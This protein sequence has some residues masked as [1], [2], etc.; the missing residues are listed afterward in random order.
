M[1]CLKALSAAGFGMP[2][3]AQIASGQ[4]TK[5]HNRYTNECER[6]PRFDLTIAG[7]INL[8]LI[9]YGVP[10]ELPRERE[11][12]ADRMMLTLGGSSAIMAH[13]LASLGSRV[14]FQSR[15]GDDHLGE[16]ALQPLQQSGVDV[17]QVRR[18]HGEI[19]TGITVILQRQR[20]RNMVTYAGT[21]AELTWDDLDFDYLTDSRHFHVSSFYLQRGLR[22]RIPELFR[23]MKDSGLTV[24]L[25]TNDDPDD[26]WEGGLDEALRYV[27]IFLPNEREAQKAAGVNDLETAIKKL[28][29]I[30]PLVVVKLGSAGAMAQR[31]TERFVSAARKV[32]AVDAVGAGDSFD[33]GFLNEYLRGGDLP[34]CLAAGNVA[35]A[36]STTRPGGIEAFR[37]SAHRKKF[38]EEC[39]AVESPARQSP[40]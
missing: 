36:F 10:E 33:A 26:T 2:E 8:D 34:S 14:G 3:N 38:F 18:T 20:W 9:L 21:I 40:L 27:D 17:S 11:L 16:L 23:Q 15:I 5:D 29:E 4:W 24:S 6:M 39:K 28:A 12:L 22:A 1:L 31:G 13:N 37:D 25:D 19:K 7:E 30:V 32:T 35:G